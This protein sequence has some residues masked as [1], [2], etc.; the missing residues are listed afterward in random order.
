MLGFMFFPFS[1]IDVSGKNGQANFK[2]FNNHF[3]ILDVHFKTPAGH[4]GNFKESV[5]WSV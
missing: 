3:E 1:F 2:V 4:F 5:S